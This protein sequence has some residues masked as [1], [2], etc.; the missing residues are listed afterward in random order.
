MGFL[1][2]L[3][4]AVRQDSSTADVLRAI[5]AL[6]ERIGSEDLAAWADHE[7]HGYPEDD[8]VPRYRGPFTAE[9]HVRYRGQPDRM[10]SLPRTAFAEELRQ[11][12]LMRLYD[13]TVVEPVERLEELVR[14]G[15]PLVRR[16]AAVHVDLV[17]RLIEMGG[18]T[19]RPGDTVDPAENRLAGNAV[20]TVLDAIRDRV[21]GL[22]LSLE[23][24]AP[25]A[26][27]EGGPAAVTPPMHEVIA[28]TIGVPANQSAADR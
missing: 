23:R 25:D 4:H 19:V 6:A 3:I 2:K 13:L 17:N 1:D 15:E 7:L 5:R 10:S 9:I 8:P 27:D 11:S 26:G 22:A 12:R 14:S 24:V 20:R 28:R 16:W 18:L 21:L